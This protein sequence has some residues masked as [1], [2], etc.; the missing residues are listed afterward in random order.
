MQEINQIPFL[1]KLAEAESGKV[2][3]HVLEELAAFCPHLDEAIAVLGVDLTPEQ[4]FIVHTL[5][6]NHQKQTYQERWKNLLNC[7]D[8]SMMLESALDCIS[9]IQSALYPY[10]SVGWMLDRLALDYRKYHKRPDPSELARFLF[11]TKGIRGIDED[12]YNPLHSNINYALQEKKGLPI[13]LAAIYMLVG[14]RLGLKIEGFNLPGHFLA[15]SCVR[16]GVLIF[17]CFREGMVMDLPQLASQSHVPL[18]QLY[19]LSRNPP[20]ARTMIYRILRNLVTACFKHGQMEPVQLYSSLMK[21]TNRHG[22]KDLIDSK[23]FHYPAG[24]LVKHSLFGYRGLVVDVDEQF[25]GDASHLAKLDPAPAKDQP[26]YHILVDGSN[27]TT[28]AAESQLC[29]DDSNREISH[30]LVT[31]FFKM[32]KNGHYIRNDEPWF[33]N[34]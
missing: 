23:S 13:T 12:Y 8:E 28:Y 4:A 33:W 15:Q 9:Q 34:Q 16:G 17:D 27:F 5:N 24:S 22:E 20:S 6:Q 26:W 3:A 32:G 14:F 19:H 11:R 25:E 10:K 2:R 1:L 21:I 7:P 29:H 30:P 31:L 18:M